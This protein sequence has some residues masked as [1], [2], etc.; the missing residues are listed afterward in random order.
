MPSSS[1]PEQVPHL[2][3][4]IEGAGNED[5]SIR[6]GFGLGHVDSVFYRVGVEHRDIHFPGYELG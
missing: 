4:E 1:E 6:A 3:H 5:C 2:T